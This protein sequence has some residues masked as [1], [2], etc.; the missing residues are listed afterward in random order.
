MDCKARIEDVVHLAG[1]STATVN[2]ARAGCNATANRNPEAKRQHPGFTLVDLAKLT[3]WKT[4]TALSFKDSHQPGKNRYIDESETAV[5]S[6]GTG[7]ERIG[8]LL[9][10]NGWE[11]HPASGQLN[12]AHSRW[13]MAL[14]EEWCAAAIAASRSL[15]A[16]KRERSGS[17]AT[18][19]QS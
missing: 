9:G 6:V 13:L 18:E 14:P 3:G 4:P 15:K 5:L 7:P 8:F 2:D 17:K 12:P 11:I 1:W 19:T 16:K 10:P